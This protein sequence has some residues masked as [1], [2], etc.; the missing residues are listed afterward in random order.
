MSEDRKRS[1]GSRRL[2][3]STLKFLYACDV[4]GV[5]PEEL[6]EVYWPLAQEHDLRQLA[7]G[8]LA[9]LRQLEDGKNGRTGRATALAKH[10]D[11][12]LTAMRAHDEADAAREQWMRLR[13]NVS[14]IGH[15]IDELITAL[16]GATDEDAA[17][18]L[19]ASLAPVFASYQKLPEIITAL[20][21]AALPCPAARKSLEPVEGALKRLRELAKIAG[22][23]E[24][25]RL[26]LEDE[27]IADLQR[28]ATRISSE[29]KGPQKRATEIWATLEGLD[30]LIEATSENYKLSRIDPVDRCI[31]RQAI[32]EIRY[33]DSIPPLVALDEALE[34][35]KVFGSEDS[36]AF[37]NGILN[38]L[39]PSG[40]TKAKAEN[41]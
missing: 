29:Q 23:I 25:P 35:A 16:K 36:R 38:A 4:A 31:L 28:R 18:L 24:D 34:L 37:I 19:G 32:Y 12:I 2:R 9:A 26:G 5:A 22:A 30:E 6:G 3:E 20:E 33:D 39:L 11:A 10:S 40:D 1:P 13:G 15:G 7:K 17:Q 14:E 8:R 21:E 27:Q 41:A